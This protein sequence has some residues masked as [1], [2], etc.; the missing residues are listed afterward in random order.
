MKIPGLVSTIV[1]RE[2]LWLLSML[3]VGLFVVGPIFIEDG[4]DRDLSSCPCSLLRCSIRVG[5]SSGPVRSTCSTINPI[6][7]AFS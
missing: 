1:A 5:R 6:V 3:A 4:N 2:W 7:K